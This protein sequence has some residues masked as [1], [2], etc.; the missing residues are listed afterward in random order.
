METI[1]IILLLTAN[2]LTS[3]ALGYLA[4]LKPW[5][6]VKPFN[7]RE[8]FTFW[9]TV[10]GGALIAYDREAWALILFAGL[11]S[12]FLNYFY[13]TSKIKVYE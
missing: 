1:T 2:I 4:T 12:A 8:C 5:P 3:N 11:L 6:N 13:I 9:L 7:C 10:I